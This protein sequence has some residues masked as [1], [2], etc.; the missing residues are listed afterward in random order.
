MQ[1]P[2]TPFLRI[3]IS[4]VEALGYVGFILA[5]IEE[6]GAQGRVCTE[7]VILDLVV[8]FLSINGDSAET[9][10]RGSYYQPPHLRTDPMSVE[11]V[12]AW[13]IAVLP[14]RIA[15]LDSLALLG[16]R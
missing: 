4:L 7:E 11:V 14:V 12:F 15:E 9:K 16:V 6:R 13:I 5:L 1:V 10:G 3:N 2:P 8:L